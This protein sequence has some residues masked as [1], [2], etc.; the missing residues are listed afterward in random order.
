M[1]DSNIDNTI[2]DE[3]DDDDLWNM[4]DTYAIGSSEE[5]EINKLQNLCKHCN[6]LTMVF[7][8][9]ESVYKCNNCGILSCEVFEQKP[10]WNNYDDGQPDN[11]RCGI[12]TNPFF[13]NSSIGTVIGG[14]GHNRLRMLQIWDQMPYKERALSNVFQHIESNLKTHKITKSIIEC[15]KTLYNNVSQLKHKD[16]PNKGKNIIIRGYNRSGIIAACAFYASKLN[17]A[18]RS[19]KEISE[20]FGL[21]ITQVTKGCRKFLELNDYQNSTYNLTSSH[22]QDFIERNGYKLKLKKQHIELAIKIAMNVEK[23]QI[24]ADHQPTSL[25]AGSLLL[26]INM[27]ELNITKKNISDIFGISEV[28]IAKTF[29]KINSFKN[30]LLDD[31]FVDLALKKMNEKIKNKVF[32]N[33]T[34]TTN[35]SNDIKNNLDKIFI[36]PEDGNYIDDN[37]NQSLSLTSETFDNIYTSQTSLNLNAIVTTGSNNNLNVSQV[38]VNLNNLTLDGQQVEKRKR[39][40]PKKNIQNNSVNEI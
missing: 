39:G 6:M 18:P 10:E 24:A 3:L 29:K 7:D 1:A 16:G 28:T 23:L 33:I 25:A 5:T 4:L 32:E 17:E 20:I 27:Y 11:G 13:P 31:K 21:K 14:K 22:A 12:A 26:V 35:I 8:S 36:I 34:K 9:N 19:V 15:A 2:L 40:R 37:L 38:A 30:I